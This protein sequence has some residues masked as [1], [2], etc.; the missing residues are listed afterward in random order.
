MADSGATPASVRMLASFAASDMRGAAEA[1]P[2]LEESQSALSEARP[3]PTVGRG[4]LD[5][6]FDASVAAA[7]Q[8]LTRMA[9]AY[10]HMGLFQCHAA[11][12]TLEGLD[13]R[14][15]YSGW[16]MCLMGKAYIE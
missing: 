4:A 8:L 6:A 12:D 7:L 16:A 1:L 14:H 15:L 2:F 11:L 3:A 5:A 13:Q 9:T 10:R